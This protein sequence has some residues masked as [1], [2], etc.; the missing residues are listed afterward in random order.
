MQKEILVSV[1][2][3]TPQVITETLYYLTQIKAPPIKISE[4]YVIT[5]EPGKQKVLK[6]LLD[7]EAGKFYKFC[8]EYEIAPEMIVFNEKTVIVVKDK[9]GK[10]IEDIRTSEDNAALANTIINFV[11]EKTCDPHTI[12]HCSIAG[13][14]KTMSIFLAY[15][16]Q[17]FGR[18]YDTL[19]HVL[20]SEGFESHPDFFYIPKEDKN[21]EIKDSF[22]NVVEVLNTGDAC[23]E[24]A[25]VPFIRMRE[26]LTQIFGKNNFNYDQMV[27]FIQREIDTSLS[28][29]V[30]ILDIEKRFIYI[31]QEST[32]FPPLELAIYLYFVRQRL[33]HSGEQS[34]I[35]FQ[36]LEDIFEENNL[37]ILKEDYSN[38]YRGRPPD[39]SEKR[40]PYFRDKFTPDLL[41]QHIS[42]INSK[43][44]SILKNT[45]LYPLSSYYRITS[46]RIYGATTYG[47]LLD[48]EKIEIRGRSK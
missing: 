8:E 31:E 35:Y 42:K 44:E 30:L 28:L 15:A 43:I 14:R 40:F 5:T 26:K 47:I 9:F 29:P 23:I 41:R 13:G 36:S 27:H 16:L 3:L 32:R 11:Q 22:G 10:P 24:L 1:A 6:T 33:L 34:Q 2:G 18:P 25:E 46:N 45:S 38:I 7:P 4:I 20:V 19:S 39:T 48:A 12:L 21:L 17:L 37:S